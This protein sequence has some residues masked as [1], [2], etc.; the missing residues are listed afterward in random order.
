MGA[1]STAQCLRTHTMLTEDLRAIP[2]IHTLSV[3]APCNFSSRGSAVFFGP[4]ADNCS[5]AQTQTYT[6]DLKRH[7]FLKCL[8][9]I[10]FLLTCFSL[11][12]FNKLSILLQRR[13]ILSMLN[14]CLVGNNLLWHYSISCDF[15]PPNIFMWTLFDAFNFYMYIYMYIFLS[16]KNNRI[17]QTSVL[18]NSD[19]WGRRIKTSLYCIVVG[20]CE[21]FNSGFEKIFWLIRKPVYT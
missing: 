17:L 5:V 3:T 21:C 15:K 12:L 16:Q 7:N 13:Q 10:T 11:N 2:C 19:I 20:E 4:A 18:W 14:Y 9:C 8:F 6:L 1:G